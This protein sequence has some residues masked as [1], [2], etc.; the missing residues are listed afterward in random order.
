MSAHIAVII[1]TRNRPV[2]LSKALGSIA[3]QT[4]QP[5]SV[6]VI[7][8]C[9]SEHEKQTRDAV[10]EA[11]K[12]LPDIQFFK[13][14][15]TNN[16][17]G[18]INTGLYLSIQRGLVPESTWIAILD[19]D[20]DW[21]P[22]YLAECLKTAES[23]RCDVVVSGLIRHERTGDEGIPLTI[24]DTLTVHDFLIQNPHVQGS[25]LFV[26]FSTLLQAGGFDE[27]LESTTDRDVCIRLL[28]LDIC[29]IGF[30][31][32]HLVHHWAI[33]DTNRL[34]EPKSSR[35]IQG[36]TGFYQ[37]YAPRMT[38]P[39]REAFRERAR[40]LFECDIEEATGLS[41]DYLPYCTHNPTDAP[42]E[43]QVPV[44]IGFIATRMSSMQ[45]LLDDLVEFFKNSS[46]QRRV[47]VCDN[48][49]STP[50]LDRLL[51]SENYRSL[52]CVCISSR[53]IDEECDQGTFGSYLQDLQ[54]RK[55]I[56]SGR[57]V[58]HYYLY[59]EAQQVPGSVVWILDDD[60]RLE[61]LTTN[62]EIVKLSLADLQNTI[63]R[64]RSEGISIAVGKITGDAPLPVQ[65][66][67]RVQ[68]LD[69]LFTLKERE[70][71]IASDAIVPAHPVSQTRYS[72]AELSRAFPDYYYD[73]SGEHTAHLEMPV[74]PIKSR[75]IIQKIPAIG[76]GRNLTRPVT[77]PHHATYGDS[78]SSS[79]SII[80][81]G[82]NTLVLN[83]GSL[84]E[85]PNLS[86]RIG[87]LNARRGDTFWC[88]LNNRVRAS[89][90]GIFPLAVRQ[91]RT[92]EAAGVLSFD[93]LL[94]DF[95]GSAFVRA[96]DE[97]YERKIGET[98]SIPRRIRLSMEVGD[99]DRVCASFNRHLDGRLTQFVMNAYRV[100][101]LIISMEKVVQSDS[102]AHVQGT[103][104]TLA[105][106]KSLKELYS[107]EN[108]WR[109]YREG[110]AW[111]EQDLRRFL[112]QF[113]EHV[114]TYRSGLSKDVLP[115][116]VERART[117]TERI[118]QKK[119]VLST[120]LL[121]YVGHGH[122]GAVFTDGTNAYKYFYAGRA[123]FQD[124]RLDVIRDRVLNNPALC[125]ICR[126]KD[127]IEEEGELIFVLSYEKGVEYSGGYLEDILSVLAD[128]RDAGIAFTNFHPR[129]FV[130]SG[131]KLKLV[132]IG[133]SIVPYNDSEF[134]QMCR[135]AY[136]MY[137]WHF[138]TDI[139]DVMS[140]ALFDGNLPELC[141]FE[142]FLEST[143]TKTKNNLVNERIVQLVSEANPSSIFDYGCG[144]GSIA[145]ALAEKGFTV[146]GYDLD[147]AVLA[148]NR[149][150]T[151]KAH[152]IDS[153]DLAVLKDKGAKFDQVICSLVLCTISNDTEATEVLQDIRS[154]VSDDGEAIIALCNPFSSFVKE[155]ETHVK[156][157]IPDDSHYH[158]PF[159]Y[160]KKMRETGKIRTECHRPF[161][162]YK[163][164][165]HHK[166]FEIETIEEVRTTDIP[167]LCPS[168]DFLIVRMKPLTIPRDEKV[169]L[170]I[171]ASAME[172]E[173]IDFQ[174][175]HIVNQLEGPRR[176][177][178]KI[179][180]TDTYTG[181]FSR[182]YA[183]ADAA[184]LR[185]GLERL[186]AEGVIDRFV[187]APDDPAIIAATYQRWFGIACTNP[188]C[189][190]GQP[191]FMSLF[192][193][194]QCHGDYILQMDSD[195]LIG[196]KDR[197]H[198]YLAE[199]IDVL[200]SD[201]KA[202][203]VSFNIAKN[204]NEPYTMGLAG[205]KWRTEVRCSLLAK[206]RLAAILPLP[207]DMTPDGTLH[208]SWHRALDARLAQSSWQSYRGGD[209]RTF[210]IHVPNDKKSDINY[211]FNVI[212]SI[213]RNHIPEIQDNSVDLMGRLADWIAPL[214][215]EYI[216]IIRGKDVPVSKMRRCIDSVARQQDRCFGIVFIDAGSSN[217][218]PEYLSEVLIPA[219]G[220]RAR[221]FFNRNPL[222]ST[223]N[224]LIAIREICSNPESVI[225]TL[226]ADDALIGTDVIGQLRK[227]Y[228]E[229]ADLTVGSML[230][231]DK[232]CDYKATF[233]DP[234]MARGGNVWQ[235]LRS[236]RKFLFDAI[237]ESYLKIGDTWIPYAED[238]A[239]MIPMVEIAHHPVFIK[240]KVYF[241]EPTGNKDA[242]TRLMR[243][244][245]IGQI[246]RKAPLR[247]TDGVTNGG[248]V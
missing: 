45:H 210:F 180:V 223:E 238:W 191:T 160:Q 133:D 22:E 244:D 209:C 19:D 101:G 100:Q 217:P 48:T 87:R 75:D 154:L 232:L 71:V 114:K 125:H 41:G 121:S 157:D 138:R 200:Q 23:Q 18:A 173:S 107:N 50:D 170:L 15:R 187:I 214:D 10:Q 77:A 193:V 112:L 56:S 130:V 153:K 221:V 54:Q 97:Y 216:F 181:P 163:H 246:M 21:A 208:H 106:L 11:S 24:P 117:I 165:M 149:K 169:S 81:R 123:N 188:R 184:E 83:P 204:G 182:E 152:Y 85:F 49:P 92:A 179:V 240:K 192:G 96:M 186:A 57:T 62:N 93:S 88:I 166:G 137:R 13:N 172:W 131:G 17:S 150:D 89:K 203:T 146:T 53:T 86:P 44:V 65:S 47:V 139:S 95:Y 215:S 206:A 212:R 236:F 55:G 142:Y 229:G 20:D 52:N 105:F 72:V 108:I 35:K 90:V 3:Q 239:F 183:P 4:R 61:Y 218:M 213:E 115:A 80:P 9:D 68:L 226:D 7:S 190:N 109:M 171:R 135:R 127:I 248:R 207:N 51:D 67:M 175:R 66:T 247:K 141:G 228:N 58:L 28:D 116:Q 231:T 29:H 111:D 126:L 199:M 220:E 158:E 144:R 12:I 164:Q 219:L 6:L 98:G 26:K 129:N 14:Q 162:W 161:S 30:V 128:C 237:P 225:I 91:E 245:I 40:N 151:V 74:L 102:F 42:V 39:E 99:L 73:Y 155:S 120:A 235:H 202:V 16:L 234:R 195:C 211:W 143:K 31:K 36:L 168:S 241:Y 78:L 134:L 32:K 69:L 198:D 38:E 230:R 222:T 145:E 140:I 34:S 196:R 147:R 70:R 148:R 82:G 227:V 159:A 64:L 76:Y 185:T 136:L 25:N 118:L 60:I 132:D 156:L 43:S 110:K 8:D 124:G 104:N 5:D 178:E 84:R 37:K 63:V 79:R 119:A 194:D 197:D 177:F 189:E 103:E 33:P 201:P 113:K 27:S 46:I 242:N 174:I 167:N 205:E 243:E 1:A 224:N 122:E 176:F 233:A 59:K 2:L 94:A